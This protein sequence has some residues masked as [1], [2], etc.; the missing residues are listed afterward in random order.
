MQP[1]LKKNSGRRALLLLANP[2]FRAA[3]DFLI[4]RQA[5]G[6]DLAEI[7]DWWTR[8]QELDEHERVEMCGTARKKRRSRRRRTK[9]KA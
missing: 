6:E 1:R 4:L 8:F 2:G 9:P 3:Y 7:S 5:A